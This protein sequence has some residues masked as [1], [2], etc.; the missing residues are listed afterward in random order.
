MN[1]S[2]IISAFDAT[3]EAEDG[4][5]L[6]RTLATLTGLRIVAAR[7][8][9]GSSGGVLDREHQLVRRDAI[10]EI[11]T[12]LAPDAPSLDVLVVEDGH[13]DRALHEVAEK[14]SARFLVFGSSHH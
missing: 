1:G 6:A 4:L 3:P 7:L 14:E 10:A 8:L 9:P 13:R 2:C 12:A 11:R 5:A